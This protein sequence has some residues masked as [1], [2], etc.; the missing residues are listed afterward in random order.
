MIEGSCHCGAV[1]YTVETA[2]ETVMACNCSICRKRG[3]LTA[4]YS[5]RAVKVTGPTAT[6]QWGDRMLVFH[7]CPNC[8]C[9]THSMPVDPASDRMSV[10]ARLMAPEVL[11]AAR[12]RRFDG[13][14]SWKFLD[15][16]G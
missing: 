15:E 9:A 7:H 14:D 10:N 2:P 11:A 1:R 13:A 4:H 5:P 12:V 16:E 6:Y 8:G 3:A